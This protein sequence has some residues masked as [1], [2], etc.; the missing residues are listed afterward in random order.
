[1]NNTAR[2]GFVVV[3]LCVIAP[4]CVGYMMPSDETEE[5]GYETDTTTDMTAALQNANRAVLS[6]P[7]SDYSNNLW[8]PSFDT[9]PFSSS[10]SFG[11]NLTTSPNQHP[12]LTK[13]SSGEITVEKDSVFVPSTHKVE[14]AYVMTYKAL[15]EEGGSTAYFH[16]NRYKDVGF[17][18]IYYFPD[19]GSIYLLA[20]GSNFVSYS[21]GEITVGGTVVQYNVFQ[22][23]TNPNGK[24]YYVDI[25][26]GIYPFDGT[27]DI[28]TNLKNNWSID[29]IF[30]SASYSF[31]YGYTDYVYDS[32]GLL[33]W[34]ESHF[35]Q[36]HHITKTLGLEYSISIDGQRLGN[37]DYIWFHYDVSTGASF[38]G[39]SGM[40]SISDPNYANKA[41]NTIT[42]SD[43]LGKPISYMRFGA[44]SDGSDP[45]YLDSVYIPS[46]Q[47]I[48]YYSPSIKDNTLDTTKLL[49]DKTAMVRIS[50][51]AYVGDSITIKGYFDTSGGGLQGSQTYPIDRSDNTITVDGQKIPLRD[52]IISSVP[53]DGSP[54]I[55]IN[56]VPLR[57]HEPSAITGTLGFSVTFDGDWDVD[58][59]L[60]EMKEYT[61][62]SYDWT[63]GTFN[64]DWNS[65]CM[66]G[67]IVSILAFLG[68]G[69]AGRRSGSK[70]GALLLV[71]GICGITYLV[72][73]MGGN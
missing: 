20:D 56:G 67:L 23:Q 16:Y 49:G 70:V 73:L 62:E 8:T 31:E 1:M 15:I 32:S 72:L 38:S 26:K 22:Q 17:N 29:V 14:G 43:D 35:S 69:L 54:G 24:P 61:Y 28:W 30:K 25:S 10:N 47:Y 36:S 12:K 5:T 55:S 3:L 63:A 19:N 52:M 6:A 2:L 66:I 33:D 57:L 68:A 4:I 51:L 13:A 71:S 48:A 27:K 42:F 34:D 40:T 50:D 65:Y 44:D 60:S 9:G 59:S 11:S 37:Y 53:I 41:V 64:I 58:V 46:V 39:L 45:E 7:Y 21:G 18:S